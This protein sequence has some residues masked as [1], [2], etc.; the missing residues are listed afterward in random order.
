M[1]TT[2]SGALS[3]PE[4]DLDLAVERDCPAGTVGRALGL[5]PD[6][7]E[8]Q[9]LSELFLGQETEVRKPHLPVSDELGTDGTVSVER[10]GLLPLSKGAQL[11]RIGD[12][13]DPA[14]IGQIAAGPQR[15]RNLDRR[16]LG[17]RTLRAPGFA[18]DRREMCVARGPHPERDTEQSVRLLVAGTGGK[19]AG[20]LAEIVRNRRRSTPLVPPPLQHAKQLHDRRPSDAQQARDAGLGTIGGREPILQTGPSASTLGDPLRTRVARGRRSE[21]R[22]D[23]RNV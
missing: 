1:A 14:P 16:R 13:S 11:A 20:E 9:Q 18:V 22:A 19:P 7:D 23:H 15:R 17:P 3:S 6:R 4:S 12:G 21:I 2:R 5:E 10:L 8:V